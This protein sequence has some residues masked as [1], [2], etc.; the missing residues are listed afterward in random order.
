MFAG[1]AEEALPRLE[2]EQGSPWLAH[3][4]VVTGRRAEA[5]KLSEKL[6]RGEPFD[7]VL[8]GID[9]AGAMTYRFAFAEGALA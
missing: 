6:A 9:S 5:E 3:A 4:Y 8:V 7:R 2:V 1:R